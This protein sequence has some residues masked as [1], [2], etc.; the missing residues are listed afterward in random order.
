[1]NWRVDDLKIVDDRIILAR[2]RSSTDDE[3]GLYE[4]DPETG[5]ARMILNVADASQDIVEPAFLSSR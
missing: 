5:R 2:W 1:M 4:F 3:D